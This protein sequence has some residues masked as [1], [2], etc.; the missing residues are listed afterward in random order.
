MG[1]SNL[2]AVHP[3]AFKS[4]S[5]ALVSLSIQSTNLTNSVPP[6]PE[7]FQI[8]KSLPILQSLVLSANKFT[9][10]PGHAFGPENRGLLSIDFTSNPI[11]RINTHA[12]LNLPNL[13]HI[14]FTTTG[15]TRSKTT[16]LKL[17]F[18]KTEVR[19]CQLC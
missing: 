4:L 3:N 16:P 5:N 8:I 10:I 18:Q 15:S 9:F 6:E 7:I 17:Q 14:G 2:T 19:H 12:F 1:C 13:E 11:T